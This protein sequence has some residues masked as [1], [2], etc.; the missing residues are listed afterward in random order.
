MCVS[1]GGGGGGR[2]WRGTEVD[3]NKYPYLMCY[4]QMPNISQIKYEVEGRKVVIT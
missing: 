2:W 4:M 1:R 3:D